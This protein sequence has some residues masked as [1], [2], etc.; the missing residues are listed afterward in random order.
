MLGMWFCMQAQPG[1]PFFE[2]DLALRFGLIFKI[3][4]YMLD[5]M[6]CVTRCCKLRCDDCENTVMVV[7]AGA[8]LLHQ[9]T[10][11]SG[12]IVG[13]MREQRFPFHPNQ[14]ALLQVQTLVKTLVVL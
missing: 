7:R 12:L 11:I 13:F 1:K 8:I 5:S 9:V 10:K 2:T 6:S 3:S 4:F 14:S